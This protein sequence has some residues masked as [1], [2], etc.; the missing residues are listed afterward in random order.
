MRVPAE[1]PDSKHLRRGANKQPAIGQAIITYP[2]PRV[3]RASFRV[4]AAPPP[5]KKG[6]CNH[7]TNIS[8]GPS[9]VAT[10]LTSVLLD[11]TFYTWGSQ[12][13]PWFRE[14]KTAIDVWFTGISVLLLSSLLPMFPFLS[15][16]SAASLR[17][18]WVW[19]PD[20][21]AEAGFEIFWRVLNMP[22]LTGLPGPAAV[23]E[24]PQTPR[25]VWQ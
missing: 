14:T 10:V 13:K 25:I 3:K 12:G 15:A 7:S 5:G 11:W 23:S 6:S 4:K 22:E 9:F 17:S 24:L 20:L 1:T 21:G 19:S 2:G 18:P 8:L 16:L